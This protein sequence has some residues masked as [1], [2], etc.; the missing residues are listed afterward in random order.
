MYIQQCTFKLLQRLLKQSTHK[1]IDIWQVLLG[2]RSQIKA[3]SGMHVHLTMSNCTAVKA[4]VCK[5]FTNRV[6]CTSINTYFIYMY[7]QIT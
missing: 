6:Q 3:G 5:T 4:I 2:N 7:L 1:G